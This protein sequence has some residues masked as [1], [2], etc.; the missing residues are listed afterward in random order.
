[1]TRSRASIARVKE[2]L[3]DLDIPFSEDSGE[4]S[5]QAG[6]TSIAITVDEVLER[7]VVLFR[8]ELATEVTLTPKVSGGL[9]RANSTMR[10]GKFAWLASERVITLDY[11]L[12]GDTLDQQ[13]LAFVLDSLRHV[14]DQMDEPLQERFSH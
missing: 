9:L 13:Q 6:T 14:A 5:V 12:L 11:E 10:L 8:A 2:L 4:L 7:A 1:M 3:D